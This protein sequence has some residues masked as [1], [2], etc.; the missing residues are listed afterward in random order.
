MNGCAWIQLAIP[1]HII[2][3]HFLPL[4]NPET[5]N[6]IQRLWDNADK[7]ELERRLRYSIYAILVHI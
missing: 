4:Q 5:R 3:I 1:S 2:R 7:L 6:E